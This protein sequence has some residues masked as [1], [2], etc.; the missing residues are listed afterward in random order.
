MENTVTRR[1]TNTWADTDLEMGT[2]TCHTDIKRAQSHGSQNI[3][4]EQCHGSQ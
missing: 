2:Y 3:D 4:G 1:R